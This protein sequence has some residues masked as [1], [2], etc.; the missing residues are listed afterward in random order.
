MPG[1]EGSTGPPFGPQ[2]QTVVW[3]GKVWLDCLDEAGAPAPRSRCGGPYQTSVQVAMVAERR[4]TVTGPRTQGAAGRQ[5]EPAS[6]ALARWRASARVFAQ[7]AL[8]VAV[9]EEEA[10]RRQRPAKE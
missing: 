10:T 1:R 5:L 8:R 4:A 3:H 9:T 7:A 2:R 6:P